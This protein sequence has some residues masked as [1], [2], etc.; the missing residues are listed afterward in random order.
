VI[1]ICRL[2]NPIQ[3]YAWGSTTAIPEL[4][5]R[6]GAAD[7]PQAELWMGA[8]RRAPSQVEIR[9]RRHSL[10]ELIARDPEALLGPA[11]VARFGHE[12]PFLFKV[13]AAAS[14]LSIQAHPDREQ[15]RSGFARENEEGIPLDAFHRSYRDANHKPEILC[16]LTPFWALKGFRPAAEI[17]SLGSQLALE[18]LNAELALLRP[19]ADGGGLKAFFSSLMRL[20]HPRREQVCTEAADRA[21][22]AA[23]IGVS[24]ESRPVWTWIGR[25]HR[26][27]PGD[28]GILA[29][30]FLNLIRLEPGDAIFLPAGQLHA[31]LEGTGIEL[32]ANSDNVLRGGLTAKHMDVPE[33]L[34]ILRFEP[35]PTGFQ[36][37]R[38]GEPGEMVYVSPAREFRLSCL[39]VSG[40]AGYTSAASRSV[41]ILLCTRGEAVIRESGSEQELPV[42]RGE[43]LLVPASLP[44]YTIRGEATFYKAAVPR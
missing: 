21:E 16:A 18:S 25:L 1:G 6:S 29:P 27:Y 22:A 14:P 34:D 12:L 10:A 11:T 36:E 42:R 39:S 20:S 30:L 31:Y 2:I 32:M 7:R 24:P 41:E 33:L 17:L 37:S 43:S 9:G 35:A 28:I 38:P 19:A 26:L 4:L 40:G 44:G 3:E 5:G 15:A 8:H 23:R 13:L